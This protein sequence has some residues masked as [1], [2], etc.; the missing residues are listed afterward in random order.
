M[1]RFLP[2]VSLLLTMLMLVNPFASCTS[3]VPS[4]AD[5]SVSDTNENTSAENSSG[6]ET[7]EDVTDQ[8]ETT[9]DIATDSEAGETSP[10]ECKHTSCTEVAEKTANCTENGNDAYSVCDEC[11]AIFNGAGEE[12]DSIPVIE[13]FHKNVVESGYMAPTTKKKGQKAHKTCS[14]CGAIMDMDN[15]VLSA[16]PT[17]PKIDPKTNMYI[18]VDQLSKKTVNGNGFSS[19]KISSDRGYVRWT[20]TAS[21][22]D[23]FINLFGDNTTVTG[24]YM[25]MKYRTDNEVYFQNWAR[26]GGSFGSTS[27]D[28]YKQELIDDE[29]WHIFIVDLTTVVSSLAEVNGKYTVRNARI[30]IFDASRSEGYF[31][32]AFIA[33]TDDLSKC[34]SVLLEGDENYCTHYFSEKY[35]QLENANRYT[36]LACGGY[37]YEYTDFTKSDMDIFTYIESIRNNSNASAIFYSGIDIGYYDNLDEIDFSKLTVDRNCTQRFTFV[38]KDGTLQLSVFLNAFAVKGYAKLTT[39]QFKYRITDEKGNVSGWLQALEVAEGKGVVRNDVDKSNWISPA[40]EALGDPDCKVGVIYAGLD[41]AA[42]KGQ[43]IS[44]EFAFCDI[45]EGKY[46]TI[47]NFTNVAL[48]G[49][50]YDTTVE[51]P[52]T[53]TIVTGD[54]SVVTFKSD[55]SADAY[56]AVIQDLKS[57]GFSVYSSDTIGGTMRATLISGEAYYSFVYSVNAKELIEI[58]SETGADKLP[59]HSNGVS[60]SDK[61][62]NTTVTQHYSPEENGMGYIFRLEDGS[63]I[64]FDG[65][66]RTDAEDLYNTLISLKL[67]KEIHIRAWVITHDHDD[68]YSAF[69]EFSEKY[70][71]K[72]KLDYVMY[73]PTTYKETGKI[74]YYGEKLLADVQRFEGVTLLPV[75]AGMTF[76]F[77]DVKLEILLTPAV[78]TVH[79]RIVDFN[80][81]SIVAR[82][83]NDEGSVMLLA[84]TCQRS[85]NWMVANIGE[86]LK[87]DMVQVAHHGCE[88]ATAKLYDAIHASVAFW[89]CYEKLFNS[90]R[91]EL[92]KQHIIEAEYIYEH[93]LHDMGSVTRALSYRPVAPDMM[94]IM[95]DSSSALGT[96]G[97]ASNA[98]IEDGVLKYDVTN[99]EDPY[100]TINLGD[101]VTEN[102][103]VIRLVVDAADATGGSIFIRTKNDSGFTTEKSI[104][105]DCQGKSTDRT[106]YLIYLGNIAGFEGNITD[107]RLDFGK[108][109]GQTIEI[110]SIEI[111]HLDLSDK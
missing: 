91:G 81:T 72:V 28:S 44:V 8:G 89:P 99:T 106:T 60:A 92:V 4:T 96:S 107:I 26:S 57:K 15:N 82:V 37:S 85:A 63:F 22:K 25:I 71:D 29:Q 11:G 90:Y 24:K 104:K 17:I 93:I 48:P 31:D 5:T 110:Y 56:N 65:G 49:A 55:I 19:P 21:G 10:S 80:D 105:I 35:E 102:R 30:D 94:D 88:S 23:G 14:D 97:D 42:Y 16:V 34:A 1:K 40:R 76:S 108:T 86:G 73:A 98:R 103:N 12:I 75:H 32:I 68:H 13:A 20:R 33:Y 36:C 100:V 69:R 84:D 66:Y 7:T 83:I 39:E 64:V 6:S 18:G 41:V 43:K 70:A 52:D 78:L 2:F 74:T 79:E 109:E 50:S 53:K 67:T 27:G 45:S 61:L 95:P 101:I 47:I 3:D 62:C 77:A 9:E 58:Y 51:A 111:F 59:E 46:D 54:G 38:E 87:S